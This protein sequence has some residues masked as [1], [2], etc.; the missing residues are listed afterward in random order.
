MGSSVLSQK[1][2]QKFESCAAHALVTWNMICW[3]P[4]SAGARTRYTLKSM[5]AVL[6]TRSL[7]Q[8]IMEQECG[9]AEIM[10]IDVYICVYIVYI[11]IY[12]YI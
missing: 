8:G 7:S 3:V 6:E 10:S 4:K 11:Y 1:R 2:W 5:D 9:G 12:T